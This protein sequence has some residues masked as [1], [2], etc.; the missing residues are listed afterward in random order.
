MK[1][2]SQP[3]VCCVNC[4]TETVVQE[5][6]ASKRVIVNDDAAILAYALPHQRR[7]AHLGAQIDSS[8]ALSRYKSGTRT[9]FGSFGRVSLLHRWRLVLSSNKMGMFFTKLFD[10]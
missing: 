9:C 2:E 7:L 6:T 3:R 5:T 10:R 8:F 1:V 4:V